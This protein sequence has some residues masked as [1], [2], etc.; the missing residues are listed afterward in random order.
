MKSEEIKYFFSK[1]KFNKS[2]LP[3]LSG[4]LEIPKLVFI[5]TQHRKQ[6]EHSECGCDIITFRV[7]V[8]RSPS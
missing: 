1:W 4:Q 7:L 8:Q 3:Q 5:T 2:V 6:L